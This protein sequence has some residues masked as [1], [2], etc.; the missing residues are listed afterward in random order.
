MD[1]K[2][3]ELLKQYLLNEFTP[4]S[5]NRQLSFIKHCR[6]ANVCLEKY[7]IKTRGCLWELCEEIRLWPPR[8]STHESRYGAYLDSTEIILLKQLG[9]ELQ[10]LEYWQFAEDVFTLLNEDEDLRHD[11]KKNPPRNLFMDQMVEAVTKAVEY[12]KTLRLGKRVGRNDE[13]SAVVVHNSPESST[14]SPRYVFTSWSNENGINRPKI[15]SLGVQWDN[16]Y[17]KGCR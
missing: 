16:S 11:V 7:G 5:S 10:S 4:P 3:Y 14:P 2:V 6:L 12:G 9:L 15:V 13:P 1:A 17:V 8:D